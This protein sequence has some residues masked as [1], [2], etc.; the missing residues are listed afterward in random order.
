M[1]SEVVYG[2][3]PPS[4][5]VRLLVGHVPNEIRLACDVD[6]DDNQQAAEVAVCLVSCQFGAGRAISQVLLVWRYQ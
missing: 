5:V 3:S 2:P 1:L 4:L 6:L